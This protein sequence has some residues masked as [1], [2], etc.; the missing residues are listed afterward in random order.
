MS[1]L[2]AVITPTWQRT[3]LLLSRCIPSVQAQDYPRVEHIVVSDG[4]DPDLQGKLYSPGLSGYPNLLYWWLP[5]RDEKQHWG[6]PGRAEALRWTRAPY[7]TYCDSDDALRPE[8]CRLL[9]AALDEHPEAGFA[10]SMMASHSPYGEQVIGAG[11]LAMGDVGTPMIM[12][13]R[14]ILEVATW[15]HAS[16][17]EDWELVWAW[18]QAGIGHV[19][20]RVITADVW[21][22]VY[23]Q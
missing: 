3:G 16:Q 14:A 22:S 9:A 20:V 5:S 7:I 15:D 2:V 11:E 12:H 13:R 1:P 6:H 17:F 8:H 21:P 19:R 10:V 18:M 4:P 23:G